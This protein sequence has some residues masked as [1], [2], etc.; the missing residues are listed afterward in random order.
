MIHSL[1]NRGITLSL[2]LVMGVGLYLSGTQ[3]AQ[4]RKPVPLDRRTCDK[5][6]GS[7]V[8]R[9]GEPLCYCFSL[10]CGGTTSGGNACTYTTCVNVNGICYK[11]VTTQQLYCGVAQTGLPPASCNQGGNISARCG[12]VLNLGPVW[13]DCS[14]NCQNQQSPTVHSYCGDTVL[15]C[16]Y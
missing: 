10:A 2:A 3:A 11:L 8:C 9:P 6:L 13:G 14:Y 15:T 16:T 5:T 12:T 1:S 7:Q 4:A